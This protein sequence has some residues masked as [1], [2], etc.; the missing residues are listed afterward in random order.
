MEEGGSIPSS[1]RSFNFAWKNAESK[2]KDVTVEYIVLHEYRR[3]GARLDS[4][5]VS[6]EKRV[7]LAR[8]KD[9]FQLRVSLPAHRIV[10]Y[11]FEIRGVWTVNQNFSSSAR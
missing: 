6:E 10:L 8:S 4:E 3:D 7:K 1:Q 9:G 11:R 5:T 2:I